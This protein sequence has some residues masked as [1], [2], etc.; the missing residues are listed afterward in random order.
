MYRVQNCNDGS[1]REVL[2]PT[3]YPID[4]VLIFTGE[5]ECY[6][7][8]EN[9]S[10]YDESLTVD[11]S[12]SD[13]TTC[14]DAVVT[15]LCEYEERTVGYAVGISFPKTEPVSRGFNECCDVGLVLA[16]LSDTDPY[17]NDFTSVFYKRQT[18][19]DTVSYEIIG[20]STGTTA[21]VD[22]THG[23]LYAFG[24]AEQPDLSYFKVEWRKILSTIGE[25]VFTIRKVLTIAGQAFNVDSLQNYN[26][27]S[28][29][30]QLADKTVRL[31]SKL[32]GKLVRIDT[33]FKN[34]DYENLKKV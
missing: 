1:I 2:L 33:D 20:Q 26:L 22:G 19:N 3:T 6:K 18:P 23:V 5:C 29:T 10:S 8:I 11:S 25:D 13:C 27:K 4:D 16:D 24:G 34:T 32:D 7:V 15:G 14:L 21:L 31:D 30:Q 28:F 17:K 12:Y 9:I